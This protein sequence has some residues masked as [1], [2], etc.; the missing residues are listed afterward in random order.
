M[1]FILIFVVTSLLPIMGVAQHPSIHYTLGMSKPH[2]HLFEAEM[3][4]NGLRNDDQALDVRLPVWRPGRYVIFDFAGG[5]QEF[6]AVDGNGKSL[7]WK[8]IDKSTWRVE[9]A[10]GSAVTVRY[11]VF[12]NEFNQ[13]TRGLNDRHGFVDGASL[14]VYV[15]KF[16]QLPCTLTVK[17]YKDWHVTT[18][19]DSD[20]GSGSRFSAPNYDHFVDC[21]IEI[22]TQKDFT[23]EVDGTPHVLS[24]FGEG[25]WDRDTLIRD[26]SK[27]IRTQ[28]DFWGEFPYKR[29]VFLLHCTPTSGGGTEHLNSMIIGAKPFV[30][31]NPD[32]YRNF[33]GLISHEYLHTWNVKHLRPKGLHPYD[34]TKENYS[35]ELWIAEGTTS[36]YGNLL[37]VR[38]GYK[39]VNKFL[40]DVANAIQGDRQRPGNKIQS[41][42]ESSFDAWIKYWRR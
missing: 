4:I 23:F 36:Y 35:K 20:N 33:L 10:G 8:K 29:Y 30:F 38:A 1:R 5:V 17:R 41:L 9:A 32:T 37:M 28:R 12:A 3:T 19:L 14:F 22:G 34:Y 15:E 13:R 40:D 6:S 16:R 39:P 25:N 24:I 11:K 18:G 2:T 31:K 42:S 7:R 26:I 27:I 21:P